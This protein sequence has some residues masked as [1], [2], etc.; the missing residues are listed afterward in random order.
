MILLMKT[1]PEGYKELS[2]ELREL[3]KEKKDN[4]LL[5]DNT[6]YEKGNGFK[7]GVVVRI[8]EGEAPIAYRNEWIG[9]RFSTLVE[10]P[11]DFYLGGLISR[12]EVKKTEQEYYGVFVP[13]ALK[14][15]LEKRTR[16]AMKA[17]RFF[18]D[19]VDVPDVFIFC[20]SELELKARESF[21]D[22]LSGLLKPR[23]L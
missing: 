2:D 20:G 18:L 1:T 17:V 6:W 4:L 12:R 14:A 21:I 7:S 15:M 5:P 13:D 3:K 9:A 22:K 23:R 16:P 8:P 10:V 11:K 19:L